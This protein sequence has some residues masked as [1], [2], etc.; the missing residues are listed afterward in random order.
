MNDERDVWCSVGLLPGNVGQPA[1]HLMK[2]LQC[3][4]LFKGGGQ[5]KKKTRSML[6][7]CADVVVIAHGR[8]HIY[9]TFTEWNAP[10]AM[11]ANPASGQ[12]RGSW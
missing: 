3:C 2:I 9:R 4:T 12:I 10:V 7:V 8:S 6:C 11:V 5:Q 1:K